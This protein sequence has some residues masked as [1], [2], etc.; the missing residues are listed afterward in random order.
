MCVHVSICLFLLFYI[1]A[2]VVTYGHTTE[3]LDIH[4]IGF[5][6]PMSEMAKLFQNVMQYDNRIYSFKHTHNRS[7][8]MRVF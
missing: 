6:V 7:N 2:S 3:Q 5:S 4:L 8:E 1:R